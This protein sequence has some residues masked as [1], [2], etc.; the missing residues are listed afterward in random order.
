MIQ[1][2]HQTTFQ[3]FCS[4]SDWFLNTRFFYKHNCRWRADS[5]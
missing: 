5:C 1:F 4:D 3:V 2:H